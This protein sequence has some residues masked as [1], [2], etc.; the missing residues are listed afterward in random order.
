MSQLVLLE[1]KIREQEIVINK[2]E[3]QGQYGRGAQEELQKI[4]SEGGK[5]ERKIHEL[6][7]KN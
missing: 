1:K 6:T 2:L 7:M 5:T 3:K 4:H